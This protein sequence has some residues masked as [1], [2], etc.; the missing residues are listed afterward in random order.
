[1]LKIPN[2]INAVFAN[3][4]ALLIL[5]LTLLLCFYIAW[6]ANAQLGYGY[7]WLYELYNIEEHIDQ[8]GPQ[9]RFRNSFALT[10]PD[11][12]KAL[13]Q[14]IVHS[15]HD[16]GNGLEKIVY[17]AGGHTRSLLHKAEIV[18]L[19]DVANLINHLHVIA[20]VSGFALVLLWISYRKSST[21]N[22]ASKKGII[23]V[24]VGVLFGIGL[25]FVIVGS[26]NI[27]YQ[28]HVWIFPED[29]QWFFYYQ[30]SLMSTLMKAPDLFAGIAIQIVILG[31]M[32]FMT[33]V[34]IF[35]KKSR[36]IKN[37]EAKKL[38][39]RKRAN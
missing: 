13:F 24:L 32:I 28:M 34:A 25:L 20:V 8:Y 30:D 7:S 10:S 36:S 16:N 12:H 1:M 17:T 37:K 3:V 23:G 15:V 21:S 18:H 38:N 39:L 26:K 31:L 14:Q 5:F 35:L 19:Q 33:L 27:F 2:L 29:H 6:M 22:Q 9:N 4:R 11:E